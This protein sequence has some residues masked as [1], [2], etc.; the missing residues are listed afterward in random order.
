MFARLAASGAGRPVDKDGFPDG[1]WT[2]D[3]LAEEIGQIATNDS[4][5][6][7]RTVQLWF[8]DNDKGISR[9]NIRWLARIFGCGDPEA[10]S[11]WQ[12][13][14]S[15]AQSRLVA[16]R[17]E[18]KRCEESDVN[19]D[20]AVEEVVLTAPA[21][22][23]SSADE[24]GAI[25]GFSLARRSEAIFSHGSPLNLP[26]T[27]FAGAVALGFLSYF[28]GIHDIVYERADGVTKQVGFIWA[29]NWTLLF[30]VFMP[31]FFAFAIELIAYWKGDARPTLVAAA[32]GA[33]I[34]E[35]WRGMV[36]ASSFTFWA[37]FLICLA[38]AGLF[39]WIGVRL[40]PLLAGGGDYAIDWGSVA[41][42]RPEVISIP[43]AIAFTGLAYLYMCL[44]F[45]LLYAGLILLYTVA[46]DLWKLTET[47]QLGKSAERDCALH[48]IGL[49]VMRA[50]FRCSVCGVLVATCM[51]LQ[52][53]YLTS[54]SPNVLAWLIG[55]F[56]S[57]LRGSDRATIDLDYS[58][59]TH[60]TSLVVAISTCIVFVYGAARLGFRGGVRGP[61]LIMTAA[62]G[63]V[64]LAYVLIGAF[65]GFSI[66]LGVATC[67][68][69]YGLFDPGFG[70]RRSRHILEVTGVS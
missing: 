15:A 7:L 58:M 69:M 14:L 8:Q 59:P 51:K 26:A 46:H 48:A 66:L 60:Y 54:T 62:L 9:D 11:A 36:Q 56:Q 16:Q 10:A 47:T 67:V 30:M 52:S 21:P 19:T 65:P 45:Y 50:I 41:I 31:L 28:I 32:N 22:T 12:V 23:L 61:L 18:R 53:L 43:V 25:R 37:V 5:A 1:A 55:D 42:I 64:V 33:Q 17:R 13:E 63:L 6:D 38:F 57:V 40:L 49:R 68:A 29:P 2:P 3:L 44:T 39:Q 34:G 4:G 35:S 20:M 70:M 27:V 24:K